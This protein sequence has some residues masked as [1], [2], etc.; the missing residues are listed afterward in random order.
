[1]ELLC[2]VNRELVNS[3]AGYS[4]TIVLACDKSHGHADPYHHDWEFSLDWK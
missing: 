3:G 1:M 4:V 2:Q